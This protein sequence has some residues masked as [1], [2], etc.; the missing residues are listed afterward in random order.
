LDGQAAETV[1][2]RLG[3]PAEMLFGPGCFGQWTVGVDDD[4]VSVGV[5]DDAVSVDVDLAGGFPMPAH[6]RVV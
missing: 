3:G 1:R 6:R 2:Q 4:A 5:D